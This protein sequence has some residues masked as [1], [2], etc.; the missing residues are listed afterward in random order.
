VQDPIAAAA[1][2]ALALFGTLSLARHVVLVLVASRSLLATVGS[3][4]PDPD[5][6]D[7]GR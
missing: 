6:A 2:P 3:E 4:R 5:E 1:M 7:E